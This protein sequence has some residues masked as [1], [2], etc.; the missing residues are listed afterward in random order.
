MTLYTDLVGK[1]LGLTH[2]KFYS[3]L[4]TL[5]RRRQTIYRSSSDS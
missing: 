1:T 4:T 5:Q 2:L 3:N